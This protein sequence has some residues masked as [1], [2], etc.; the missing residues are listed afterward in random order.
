MIET[1]PNRDPHTPM[2]VMLSTPFYNACPHSGEPR[3]GSII[4]ITYQPDEHLIELHSIEKYL[5]TLSEVTDALDLETVAQLVYK[6]CQQIG[7]RV[8]VTANYKLRNGLEMI[9]VVGK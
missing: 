9:V 3:E 1:I 2:T 7:I 8:I 4:T 6:E 5:K